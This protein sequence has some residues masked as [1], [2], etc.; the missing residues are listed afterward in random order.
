MEENVV[1]SCEYCQTR[2]PGNEVLSSSHPDKKH[3][4]TYFFPSWPQELEEASEILSIPSISIHVK[5][6]T[7]PLMVAFSKIFKK[8]ITEDMGFGGNDVGESERSQKRT[9]KASM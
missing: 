8:K 5:R 3:K 2:K 6:M 4:F 9:R 1:L 7:F